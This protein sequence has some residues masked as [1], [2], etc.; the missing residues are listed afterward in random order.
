MYLSS[1]VLASKLRWPARK[2]LDTLFTSFFVG[3][4]HDASVYQKTKTVLSG[5]LDCPS[6]TSLKLRWLKMVDNYVCLIYVT[7]QVQEG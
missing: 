7:G 1:P 3:L 2:N 6:L 4:F 5:G